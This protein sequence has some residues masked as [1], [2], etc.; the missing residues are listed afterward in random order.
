M[1]AFD[2]NA[3]ASLGRYFKSVA[4]AHDVTQV[5]LCESLGIERGMISRVW[6]GLVKKPAH[7]AAMAEYFGLTLEEVARVRERSVSTVKREW[8]RARAWLSTSL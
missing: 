5:M 2:D 4:Q 7:Y 6:R 3:R 1:D 8:R